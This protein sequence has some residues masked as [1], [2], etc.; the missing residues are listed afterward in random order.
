VI[1]RLRR[2]THIKK[3][4]LKDLKFSNSGIQE[5]RDWGIGELGN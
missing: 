2:L 4:K 1:R 3:I 5:F